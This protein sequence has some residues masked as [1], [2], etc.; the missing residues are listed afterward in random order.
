MRVRWLVG[1]LLVL[2][3][4]VLVAGTVAVR[5]LPRLVRTVAV[6]RLEA[7]TN[8]PVSIDAVDVSLRTGRFSVRG[9]RVNDHDGG[10]LARFDLLDGR[11]HRRSLLELHLWIE[12]VVL[13]NG[14]VRIVRVGPDRF[15]ISD[16]LERPRPTASGFALTVD[17]FAIQGGSV[18]LEDRVLKPARTWRS[19]NIRLDARDLTTSARK[20]TAFGSTTVAGALVTVRVSNLQLFPIHMHADVN[21]RDLDLTLVDLY[22]P[23]DAPT[24]VERGVAHAG[25]AIDVDAKDGV[26]LNAE[27]VVEQVSMGRPEVAGDE[28]TSPA[29]RFLVRE[30]RQRPG[31]I[32]L[33]Y[34][35]L[36]G[37]VTVI[38]PTTS[39]PTRLT[40]KGVTATASD[41]E[42][43]MKG[44]AKIAIYGTLPGV[45]EVDI[46]G[47]AGVAPR[48][49]DVRVR[50]RALAL[51]FIS[52]HLPFEARVTGVG[53][54]DVRVVA[55]YEKTFGATVTG[56]VVLDNVTVGDGVQTPVSVKRVVAKGL[57]YTYPAGV[58]IADL[59]LTEPS[60]VI[61]RWRA[62]GRS[63]LSHRPAAR[64]RRPRTA[65]RP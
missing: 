4:L 37:D 26:M 58:R 11:I 27:G 35:S 36:E 52:R 34:A 46:S 42:Q 21:I 22:L 25:L 39:P 19:D 44:P 14:E 45:G 20:G 12:D 13:T 40:L 8:R 33:R 5:S 63:K 1:S 48:R 28:I 3:V 53:T 50:A 31:S 41:L 7:L 16:I 18:T 30:L 38:D 64:R 51:P 15:N 54:V 56:D 43:P 9:L 24:A 23:P 61:E 57:A 59:T 10:L 32:A 60:T 6:W 2:V 47:T 29:I 65:R 17:H 49:A 62:A 55:T